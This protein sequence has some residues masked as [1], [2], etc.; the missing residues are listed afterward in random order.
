VGSYVGNWFAGK[1][2]HF[3]NKLTVFAAWPEAYAL[4]ADGVERGAT[5]SQA[6]IMQV[7]TTTN[8]GT[9]TVSTV[10]GSCTRTGKAV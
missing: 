9:A 8:A 7:D 1:T 3:H 10:A 2:R 6:T 4:R 5:S